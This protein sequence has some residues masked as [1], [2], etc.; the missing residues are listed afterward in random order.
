MLLTIAAVWPALTGYC[1]LAVYGTQRIVACQAANRRALAYCRLAY[2]GCLQPSPQALP[3]QD[4]VGEGLIAL[5][6]AAAL[7]DPGQGVRFSTYAWTS[8]VRAMQRATREYS[9]P[10]RVPEAKWALMQRVRAC[11]AGRCTACEQLGPAPVMLLV[12]VSVVR[13]KK[14][15]GKVFALLFEG[16]GG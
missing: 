11:C 4:L 13:G 1:Q 16:G 10:L 14:L 15:T 12:G 5:E 2:R 8:V 9:R 3:V 7:F 6:R